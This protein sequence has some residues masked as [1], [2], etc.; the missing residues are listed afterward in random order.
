[1]DTTLDDIA[2]N[3]TYSGD[4]GADWPTTP[5]NLTPQYFND[6]MQYGWVSSYQ[7][8]SPWL[9]LSSVDSVTNVQGATATVKFSGARKI[10]LLGL[11]VDMTD[12]IGS[13]GSAVS[14]YGAT[15]GN[16]ALYGVS[17]DGAPPVTLNGSAPAFR[18]QAL[19]VSP[20]TW[21]DALRED[22]I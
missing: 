2:S 4:N 8:A 16:H 15:S 14:L 11:N 1:M 19:L 10:S 7:S 6:T 17:L 12:H 22:P 21:R 13:T 9:T 5:N 18:A 3:I 20:F